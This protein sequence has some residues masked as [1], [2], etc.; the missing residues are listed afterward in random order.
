MDTPSSSNLP[1]ASHI[2]SRTNISEPSVRSNRTKKKTL[3][4]HARSHRK[5]PKV[6]IHHIHQKAGH[7]NHHINQH[8]N[9]KVISQSNG[10][11]RERTEQLD[12]QIMPNP[13]LI[14]PTGSDHSI[15]S[16]RHLD[17]NQ[18]QLSP[19]CIWMTYS[20]KDSLSQT[21]ASRVCHPWTLPSVGKSSESQSSN[22]LNNLSAQLRYT[23]DHLSKVAENI[24]E[25]TLFCTSTQATCW[26]NLCSE[27]Q[28]LNTQ[29]AVQNN[30][31]KGINSFIRSFSKSQE[32]KED[33]LLSSIQQLSAV[34]ES[35]KVNLLNQHGNLI[36]TFLPQHSGAQHHHQWIL[37][38]LKTS[39]RKTGTESNSR[40]QD[41]YKHSAHVDHRR[42]SPRKG[43]SNPNR[44]PYHPSDRKTY[45]YEGHYRGLHRDRT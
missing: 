19:S 9:L 11:R 6:I 25:F 14:L 41:G 13:A 22:P 5:V 37:T 17:S 44:E 23:N 31:L 7:L 45:R 42:F 4:H 24:Q 39:S 3:V 21:T 33:K 2:K 29:L 26:G 1:E 8:Q 43:A 35:P 40:R 16:Q 30:E 18:R 20:L 36:P 38:N 10:T 34:I 12:H 15:P 28:I 32:E 27:L